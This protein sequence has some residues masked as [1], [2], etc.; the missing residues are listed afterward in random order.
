MGEQGEKFVLA[1]LGQHGRQAGEH[2]TVVDPGVV[3]VAFAGGQQAEMDRRRTAAAIAATKEPV[4]ASEADTPQRVLAFVVVDVQ[5][6]V[7]DVDAQRGPVRQGVIHRPADRAL[8]QDL[9]QFRF[10]PGVE[11]MEQGAGN[12][13]AAGCAIRAGR[14][15]EREIR[16]LAPAALPQ[17]PFRPRRA[18]RRAPIGWL[19]AGN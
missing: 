1:G 10:Q 4:T 5:P 8:G 3:A 18:C 14:F 13:P 16:P 2:V 17:T 7:F 15:L 6:A 11:A 19:E 12:V 9:R